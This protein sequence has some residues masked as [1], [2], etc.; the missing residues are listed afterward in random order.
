M[1]AIICAGLYP[2]RERSA[3]PKTEETRARS[4]YPTNTVS[5]R[6]KNDTDVHL[7]PTSV[8]YG[9]TNFDSRFLLYHEKERTTKVYIRDATAVGPYPLLLFGG[10]IKVNHER[11]SARAIIGF[12]FEPRRAWRFIQTSTRT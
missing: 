8:C 5:V 4:R 12:T 2:T 1:R 10:K 9:L 11:S 7:H 6:T 3:A